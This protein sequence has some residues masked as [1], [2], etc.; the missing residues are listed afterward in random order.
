MDDTT[1]LLSAVDAEPANPLPRL[2]WADHLD[3]IGH[4]VPAEFVRVCCRLACGPELN[5]GQIK[6]LRTQRTH[7]FRRFA[8]DY[9]PAFADT[10]LDDTSFDRGVI[11]PR[12]VILPL[13]AFVAAAPH[14]WPVLPVRHVGLY[15]VRSKWS[16]SL[17]ECPHLPRLRTLALGYAGH[18]PSPDGT[19]DFAHPQTVP[20][21]VLDW[22]AECGRLDGLTRL[23]VGG[24]R[25][26]RQTVE[27][28]I[29]AGWASRLPADQFE[30][31]LM[32]ARNDDWHSLVYTGRSD[33]TAADV[34]RRL[35]SVHG[36]RLKP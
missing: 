4:P 8:T 1:A 32:A 13:Q 30:F 18:T 27:K 35:L 15:D 19:D 16:R 24:A 31:R 10:G 26:R 34:L 3:D 9:A 12:P 22:L 17:A 11:R 7:L 6:S 2:V 25:P 33:Q 28:L 20:D 21:G 14:W 5:S 36:H 23:L 29:A